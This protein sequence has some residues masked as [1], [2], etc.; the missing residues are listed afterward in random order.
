MFFLS[1]VTLQTYYLAGVR[2]T[3]VST[4]TNT[5]GFVLFFVPPTISGGTP[6]A[7]ALHT[8]APLAVTLQLIDRGNW[9]LQSEQPQLSNVVLLF[10]IGIA[11]IS[12]FS[13][14]S[15]L[16]GVVHTVAHWVKLYRR[17]KF[18]LLT[19]MRAADMARAEYIRNASL[20][21]GLAGQSVYGVSSVAGGSVAET[22][23]SLSQFRSGVS[24]MEM[25]D[26]GRGA[27]GA[28]SAAL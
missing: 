23:D 11:L 24:Y 27:G 17:R 26:D 8:S 14:M 28:A 5:T 2:Q 4:G 22:D 20:H 7:T 9:V 13:L 6:V 1:Q 12:T 16:T 19:A 18:P 15:E 3:T 25:K 10:T 21:H